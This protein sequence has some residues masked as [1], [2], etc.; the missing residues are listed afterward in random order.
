MQ[1][2]VNN[3]AVEYKDE[4]AGK[5]LLFLHGWQ[6]NLESFNLISDPLCK[7]YRVVRLDLPGFGKTES[8]KE[9]WDLETYTKFVNDFI[10][11]TKIDVYAMA[12]HSFGGRITIKG[13]STGIFHP[14]KIILIGSAGIAR[15]KTFKNYF[16]KILAK[17]GNFITYIPP[18]IFWREQLRKEMYR[19]IAGPDYQH[20]G[21]LRKTFVKIINEDLSSDAKKITLPALLIW[22]AND[23]ET[24]L[25]DGK[26]LAEYISGSELKV[27]NDCGHFVHREKPKEIATLIE[28]FL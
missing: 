15:R 18:L 16:Y 21:S 22:G 12:G 9:P 17:F 1:V 11:K 28:N 3:L 25:S 4:G 5:T 24:P 14:S 23:T 6:D 27:F 26:R 2:I 8:P 20:A 13:T 19:R 10:A 7:E